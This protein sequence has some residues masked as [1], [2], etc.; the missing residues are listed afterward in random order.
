M[1]IAQRLAGYSLGAADLLR[2]AMGKKKKEILEK[3]FDRFREGMMG[4][5]FPR[6]PLRPCGT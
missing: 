4:K 2:R 3:E 6:R 1:A 5:A